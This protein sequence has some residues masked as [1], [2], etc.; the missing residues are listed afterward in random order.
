[1]ELYIWVN[2]FAFACTLVINFISKFLSNHIIVKYSLRILASFIL[3]LPGFYSV[4][5]L[6]NWAMGNPLLE[7]NAVLAFYQTNFSEGYSY[8]KDM[9]HIKRAMAVSFILIFTYLI[10]YKTV[11]SSFIRLNRYSCCLFIVCF[12]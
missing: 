9:I 1:M 8:L 4:C 10:A 3:L 2:F 6:I 7:L 11:S 5:Y 12:L